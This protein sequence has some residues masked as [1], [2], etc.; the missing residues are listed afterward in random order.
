L[1][2]TD[3]EKCDIFKHNKKRIKYS[4]AILKLKFEAIFF[5]LGHSQVELIQ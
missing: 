4:Q 3:F 2:L 5:D 1:P